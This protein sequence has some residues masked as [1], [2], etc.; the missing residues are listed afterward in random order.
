MIDL[1][2]LQNKLGNNLADSNTKK[3]QLEDETV[4]LKNRKL[5]L[6]EQRSQKEDLL[7]RTRSQEGEYQK[8]LSDLEQQQQ[9]LLEEITDIEDQLGKGFDRSKVPS[10]QP[11]LL[12]WPVTANGQRTGVLTQHYGET[13]YSTRFYKGR[14]HNGTDIG[15]PIGTEVRAAADGTIVHVDYNGYYYQYGR[16]ILINHS[17][18]LS[19]LYAHLSRSIVAV[20]QKVEK[21]G[22][23]GY[24]GNTGFATGPHLHFG[25]Y[26]TPAGGWSR[27]GS[28]EAGGLVSVP[29]A[30]GLVPIGVTLNPEQYL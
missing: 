30:S 25:L 9:A 13:A 1:S 18:G 5:I 2:D 22:L 4:N 26:A 11:G 23:I 7:V 6:G 3:S 12:A 8:L 20:G 15:V 14:P 27:G 16:Y 10:R 24:A 21:G 29:P 28:K 19:T 17:N